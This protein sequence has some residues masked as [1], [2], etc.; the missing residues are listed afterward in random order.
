M[1]GVYI[2]PNSQ[3]LARGEINPEKTGKKFS[4]SNDK[5]ERKSPKK[6][7]DKKGIRG[8]ICKKRGKLRRTSGKQEKGGIHFFFK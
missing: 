1:P 2:L 7:G 6:K 8:K 3:N 5:K 4:I